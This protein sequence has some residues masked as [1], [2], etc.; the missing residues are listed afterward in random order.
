[1]GEDA[2]EVALR[3]DL[4]RVQLALDRLDRDDADEAAEPVHHRGADQHRLR[5]AVAEQRHQPRPVDRAALERLGEGVAIFAEILDPDAAVPHQ[6][7]PRRLVGQLDL[8]GCVDGKERGRRVVEHRLVEAVGVDQL[9]LLVAHPL[10][11][12]VEHG[13][14]LGE[15]AAVEPVGEALAEVGEANR[16]D[17][18]GQL[19]VGELD[20]APQQIGGA[21]D[22]HS[23]HDPRR[24]EPFHGER[25][26]E[27]EGDQ[28]QQPQAPGQADEEAAAETRHSDPLRA[29]P[30]KTSGEAV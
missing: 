2:D 5:N 6:Q 25:L 13:A 9:V 24:A 11:R 30:F 7:P 18:P 14:Q 12:V 22:E 20:V 19:H 16:V 29:N 3:G 10:D 4:D 8:A 15:A 17:E 26:D 21:D 23:G 1:M 27:G 28:Q